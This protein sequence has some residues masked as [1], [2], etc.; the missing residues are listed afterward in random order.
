MVFGIIG[1]VVALVI[2][3]WGAYKNVSVLYLAPLAAVIVAVTNSIDPVTAFTSLYIGAVEA[4]AADATVYE[5]GGVAGMLIS[6]FPTVFL[7]GLL[8]KVM[9]DSG[10]ANSIADTL[11]NKFVMPIKDREKK[12]RVAVLIMLIIECILAFGGVDGFVAVFATF[13]ICMVLAE[14]VGI[15]RRYV[16]AMLC[17]SSG[18]NSAPFVLSIN[19][20]VSMG[21]LGT[22]AGA[23]PIPGF[24]SFIVIE[25]GIYFVCVNF[26][27]RAMRRKETFDM[28]NVQLKIGDATSEKPHFVIS[29]LPLVAV[30]VLFVIFQNASFSLVVGI[31]LTVIL[32]SKFFPKYEG[33]NSAI[34]SWV[35]KIVE[36]LNGGAM[37]GASAL[38]TVSA[39]AGFAAVVQHTDAFNTFVNMLFGLPFPPMVTATVLIIVIVTF[40]SSPPAALSIGLGVILGVAGGDVSTLG[41]NA[42]GLARVAAIAVTTFETL[43]VNGLII[44][45][46]G[47]AQVKIK[48][49]YLPM[50]LQTVIMTLVGTILCMILVML[51]PGIV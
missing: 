45:T 16:P 10:A 43:P 33:A 44:L 37:N 28:G 47:L 3:L 41:I 12:A 11:V 34:G 39:A 7:G 25:I 31:L 42:D 18:A 6:I 20:I 29:V 17:L 46:T 4:T 1:I 32:M 13:P 50:F 30:F 51:F 9:T 38:M 14:N 27:I 23:A 35:G 49:A 21:I 2:F 22:S 15:P 19:N 26:V 5:V 40:T 48:D 8:G 36:S 24:I